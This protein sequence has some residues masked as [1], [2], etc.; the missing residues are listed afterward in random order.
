MRWPRS[1]RPERNEIFEAL[2][3]NLEA[4][5]QKT[6]VSIVRAVCGALNSLGIGDFD[7][8]AA[9]AYGQK[10]LPPLGSLL[11]HEDLSV[12]GCR[13]AGA[14]GAI[15]ASM[16]DDQPP[17]TRMSCPALAPYITLQGWR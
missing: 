12:Q 10:F 15:A 4:S 16:G 5:T 6:N 13:A 9:K 3:R 1:S 11:A 2:L 17:T 7:Q 14:I 8:E